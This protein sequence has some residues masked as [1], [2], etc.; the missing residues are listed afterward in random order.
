[1]IILFVVLL[2]ILLLWFLYPYNISPFEI[3][4]RRELVCPTVTQREHS[5]M[6]RALIFVIQGYT[7]KDTPIIYKDGKKV[8]PL[9]Y[10]WDEINFTYYLTVDGG[11][12][13]DDNQ[14]VIELSDF[15]EPI[16][17]EGYSQRKL[18]TTLIDDKEDHYLW[19]L[20]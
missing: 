1:M 8:I 5:L 2:Y 13:L 18:T 15:V 7:Y 11:K 9:Q 10:D 3:A 17:T 12:G 20:K 19:L 6:P 16:V 14:W 4:K